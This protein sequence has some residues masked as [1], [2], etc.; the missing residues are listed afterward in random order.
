MINIFKKKKNLERKQSSNMSTTED[1]IEQLKL[2][3][4][5]STLSTEEF[6]QFIISKTEWFVQ[7]KELAIYFFVNNDDDE[8]LEK[9]ISQ[10]N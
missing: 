8:A 4:L 3:Q 10:I 2:S 1:H 7:K 6:K 5:A 9:D